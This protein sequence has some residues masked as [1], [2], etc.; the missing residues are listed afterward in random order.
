[1]GAESRLGLEFRFRLGPGLG[2]YLVWVQG[3]RFSLGLGFG[4]WGW[5]W[6][7]GVRKGDHL[8]RVFCLIFFL[9]KGFF[10]QGLG[11]RET[12]WRSGTS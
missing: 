12:W 9:W 8:E 1:L 11:F 3:S 6:G 5:G 2:Q 7:L 4:V 10:V